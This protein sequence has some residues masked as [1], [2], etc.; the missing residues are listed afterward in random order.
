MTS[1]PAHRTPFFNFKAPFAEDPDGYMAVFRQTLEGGG[2]ILQSA[3]DEFEERLA[4]FIGCRFTIGTSDCTNAMQLGIRALDIGAGDEVIF[5]SHTFVATAQAI[6][7]AGAVPVPV[8]MGPDRM[9]D[10]ASIEASITQR[11][12][13]I[14]VTQLN[15]RVCDMDRVY[16]V[17]S[18]HGL[19]VLEDSAQALGASYRGRRAG[20]VGTFGAFS[21][22]PSKLLGTFGDGGALTTDDEVLAD[23]VFRMRNH[24]ANRQKQLERDSTVWSTNS[25]LD[26]LHAALLNY[27]F[28][29]FPATL[30]RRRQ[31]ARTYHEAFEGLPDFGRP[32]GPDDGNEHFDVFQN[33][34]IDVG[35]RDALRADLQARGVGT[36]LQW[37]G[38]AVHQLH[39]L[40]F[41]Q[42]LPRTER[43]F[44][45]CLLLPMNQYLSDDD[46]LHVCSSVREHYG[47]SA[48]QSLAE[49]GDSD[50]V[51]PARQ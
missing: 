25:R 31:I 49:T 8:E 5:C 28:D 15:G 27:K 1:T 3:V 22:Y 40:G 37:G 42:R 17:A 45:R 6:H 16:A 29:R 14:M 12:K 7:F 13:A 26:N 19:H 4:A 36:I 41:T 38:A 34:E 50:L 43:F 30:V 24:G 47:L 46:V 2:I 51:G 18:Q 21:F 48:W 35:D 11:T 20:A 32:P 10:P 9:I 44:E 33:Y 23:R 39:G